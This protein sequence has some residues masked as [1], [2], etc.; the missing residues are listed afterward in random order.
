[1]QVEIILSMIDNMYNASN[2]DKD[3]HINSHT[4]PSTSNVKYCKMQIQLHKTKF[5]S[6]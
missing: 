4:L 3:M 5:H 2:S 6:P 1:M